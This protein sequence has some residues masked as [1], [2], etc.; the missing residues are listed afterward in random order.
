MSS[1]IERSVSL[2]RQTSGP[3]RCLSERDPCNLRDAIRTPRRTEP[4][5]AKRKGRK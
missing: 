2:Y 3:L 5:T 4:Q 1:A